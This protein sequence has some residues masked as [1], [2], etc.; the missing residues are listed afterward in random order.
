MPHTNENEPQDF[1]RPSESYDQAIDSPVYRLSELMFGNLL[2]AYVLGF[3]SFIANL[4]L[5]PNSNGFWDIVLW[6]LPIAKY[7]SISIAFAYLTASLYV[8]YH[9]GILTMPHMPL[10]YLGFDFFLALTQAILF[11][12]S[13]FFP[14]VFPIFLGVIL[15]AA[16]YR[17]SREHKRLVEEFRELYEKPR[18]LGERAKLTKKQEFRNFHDEFKKHL[19][20]YP[21]LSGWKSVGFHLKA[22]VTLLIVASAVIWYRVA[23]QQIPESLR[24]PES[25]QLS[26]TWITIECIA[27]TIIISAYGHITLR[28]RA[29]FLSNRK[30]KTTDMDEQFSGLLKDL[31]RY[32]MGVMIIEGAVD[33]TRQSGPD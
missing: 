29:A 20:K 22:I 6:L 27:V 33:H 3:I 24:L 31:E 11:G 2:A 1:P 17:Q 12:F 15:I 32:R 25:W 8:T 28:K 16:I 19:V 26:E 30:N 21:E 23:L 14:R 4:S 5:S 10:L 13:M 18:P 9:A 7:T